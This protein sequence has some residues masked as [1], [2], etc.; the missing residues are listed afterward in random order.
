MSIGVRAVMIRQ[1]FKGLVLTLVVDP[2]SRF[3]TVM[4]IAV[5]TEIC[6]SL[7]PALTNLRDALEEKAKAFDKIIKIGRTHLQ[8]PLPKFNTSFLGAKKT[9]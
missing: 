3:P 2:Y 6:N 8:V 9:L 4:H 5:V 7:I 1:Y